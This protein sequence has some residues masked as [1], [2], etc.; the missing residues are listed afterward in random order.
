MATAHILGFPRIG[1]QRELKQALDSF[2]RGDIDSAQ[3]EEAAL[4]LREQHWR[5]QQE[6]GLDGIPV[7]EYGGDAA[8][9]PGRGGFLQAAFG[10]QGNPVRVGQPQ[11][12]RLARQTAAEDED[13]V[14]AQIVV[15]HR[16]PTITWCPAP[17]LLP[18]LL[19]FGNSGMT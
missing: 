16:R 5:L 13:V 18:W 7:V 6:S 15:C 8:L 12:E 2:W 1:R 14:P 19:V 4:D 17:E 11:S 3:L 9:G 10:E